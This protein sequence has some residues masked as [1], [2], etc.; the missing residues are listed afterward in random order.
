MDGRLR[1]GLVG[2]SDIAATRVAP[3]MRAAGQ[4][5]VAVCS[6]SAQHASTYA[7]ANEIPL[8]TSHLD[9]LLATDVDAVYISSRN[10]EHAAQAQAAAAVG[11]HVLCEKPIATTLGDA[12]TV[13]RA[14][15]SAGVVLAVNHHLPGAGTHRKIRELV[16]AGA[17]GRPLSVAVRHAVMLP[18]RLRGWRLS[19]Q[20]G[21]GVILDITVHDASVVIPLIGTKP[22]D[23]TALAVQQGT[24]EAH[25]EDAAMVGIRFEGNV[26]VQTHDAFTS[27]YTPTRL[28]VHGDAGS[29]TAHGVMTQ[30]PVGQVFLTDASGEREVAVADR[31]DL[32]DIAV[33]AFESAVRGEGRPA[34]TGAEGLA[35][36]A[37]AQ[38]ALES[39]RTGRTTPVQHDTH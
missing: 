11:K 10:S 31:R 25:S 12:E 37:L 4:A 26:L 34:V 1:W 14:C 9:E 24:W 35:A 5:V 22:L 18:E 19:D 28:E 6:G 39:S 17:I 16:A 23:V 2:A 32:Y 29:I 27:A 30:D 33:R 8:A 13:V 15:Q 20:P 7:Q 3:A 21:A 38:A 36:Y